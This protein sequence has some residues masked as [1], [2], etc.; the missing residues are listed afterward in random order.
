MNSPPINVN[1]Q[2]ALFP[3]DEPL[4]FENIVAALPLL[5]KSIR[6]YCEF[7]D[8]VFTIH[9]F[10]SE[11]SIT[12]S[13]RGS[14]E[15]IGLNGFSKNHIN[16]IRQLFVFALNEDKSIGTA[17][18]LAGGL[19]KFS[20]KEVFELITAG[21]L[22]IKNVWMNH[23]SMGLGKNSYFAAKTLLLL[24]CRYRIYDWSE[25]YCDFIST[26]LPLPYHDKFSSVKSGEAFLALEEEA[27]IASYLDKISR[28]TVILTSLPDKDVIDSAMIL[29]AFQF[30][31]R[32][33]QIAMLS[34]SDVRIW[35]NKLQQE[36]SV[37]LTF[38]MVKQ[39]T[40]IKLKP[41][42]RKVKYEWA[43]IFVEL[44]RRSL[45]AGG[46][47]DT[48]IFGPISS[49]DAARRIAQALSRLV[50]RDVAATDLRHTAAQRLVDAGAS[51]EELAE[52][53]GHT[54]VTTG[55]VYFRASANQAALVNRALG[56][57]EIYQRVARI[58]HDRFIS[59]DELAH[60]KGEQQIGGVPHG[61]PIVGIG[62]AVRVN[63]RAPTIPSRPAMAAPSSCRCMRLVF[64]S[65]S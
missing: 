57:S 44:Y 6:Y 60:L 62:A 25:S 34:V 13:V 4:C 42:Q 47:E 1:S 36:Q 10:D 30:G 45:K 11:L 51:Q 43:S 15:N 5:P 54:D 52:F 21:P 64:M 56:A 33:V 22:K 39:R 65:R 19:R 59:A 14:V 37:H 27:R 26:C 29:C 31:M 35:P 9:D 24:C 23:M 18:L 40:R 63:P 2:L 32:P 38:R 49:R 55:L 58:A 46:M 20:E 7:D 50:G 17:M 41:L 61:I 28:D 12:A 48:K 53:M 3:G 8:Q 16:I